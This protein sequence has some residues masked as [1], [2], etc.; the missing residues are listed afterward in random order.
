MRMRELV[1]DPYITYI[2]RVREEVW[3]VSYWNEKGSGLVR[4][5]IEVT[6]GGS[7]DESF[8][9][10]GDDFGVDVLRFH[11]CLTDVLGFLEKLEWWFEQDIDDEEEEDEEGE[12]GSKV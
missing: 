3:F 5:L 4:V 10:E 6:L 1:D 7:G 12:G 8:L 2:S 11:N 9:E